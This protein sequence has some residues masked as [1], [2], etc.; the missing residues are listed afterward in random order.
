MTLI[1]K[2]NDEIQSDDFTIN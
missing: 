1:L 2:M